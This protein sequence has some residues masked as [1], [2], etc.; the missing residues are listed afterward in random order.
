MTVT[1]LFEKGDC[2]SKFETAELAFNPK[3]NFYATLRIVQ[4]IRK[5]SSNSSGSAN[6]DIRATTSGMILKSL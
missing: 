1:G 5:G 2:T 4:I 6:A 3:A